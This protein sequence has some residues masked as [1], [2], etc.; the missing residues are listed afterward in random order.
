MIYRTLIEAPPAPGVRPKLLKTEVV[1][2]DAVE[3]EIVPVITWSPSFRPVRISVEESLLN[4]KV[5]ITSFG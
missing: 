1:G 3:L 2:V 5:T 4:P